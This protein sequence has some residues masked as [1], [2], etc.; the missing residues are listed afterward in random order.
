M[1]TY[2]EADNNARNSYSPD[3]GYY[4]GEPRRS[5]VPEIPAL[6]MDLEL[7]SAV[8]IYLLSVIGHWP[9]NW[10]T[11][12]IMIYN[13]P[14]SVDYSYWLKSLNFQLNEFTIQ[15]SSKVLKVVK[16]KFKKMLSKTLGTSVVN[17]PMSPSFLVCYRQVL[18]N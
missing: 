8:R 12:L 1:G 13:I 16:P 18:Y 11:S 6:P 2:K 17:S 5:S 14:S 4:E 15:K 9:I 10:Y 7:Y 3:Y